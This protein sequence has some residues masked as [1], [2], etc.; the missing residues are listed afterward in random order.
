MIF[1][2]LSSENEN[3][4]LVVNRNGATIASGK[5]VAE[6]CSF[7]CFQKRRPLDEDCATIAR[8]AK[9]FEDG[10]TDI[11][12]ASRQRSEPKLAGHITRCRE[13]NIEP[14][15]WTDVN[16]PGNVWH[17]TVGTVGRHR[18]YEFGLS[19]IPGHDTN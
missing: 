6:F 8:C 10:V 7:V 16:I 12:Q 5:I 15:R 9:S 11:K 17:G 3:K 4:S 2:E 14:R 18:E 1:H 13:R 19:V